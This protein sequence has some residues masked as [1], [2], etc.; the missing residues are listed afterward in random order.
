MY[1]KSLKNY[2][3]IDPIP[4]V[5]PWLISVMKTVLGQSR[6]LCPQQQWQVTYQSAEQ[7]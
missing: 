2:R 5:H 7:A 1:I 4:V 6:S 3:I